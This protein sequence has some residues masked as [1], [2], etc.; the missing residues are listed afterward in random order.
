MGEIM[1]DSKHIPCWCIYVGLLVASF[2][3]S[4]AAIVFTYLTDNLGVPPALSA[5]WRL[6][7]V[8]LFQFFPC[9]H[10]WHRIHRID[11]EIQFLDYWNKEG[12]ALYEGDDSVSSQGETT[13]HPKFVLPQI[14]R[15]IPWLILSGFFFGIHFASW[16]YSLRETSMVHSL[17]WVSMGPII[18]NGGTWIAYLLGFNSS[19]SPSCFETGGAMVGLFG[20][21]IMLLDIHT[22]RKNSH[23]PS[24][25]GD[26]IALIGAMA[27]SAYLVIG[28]ELRS[29][30]PLWIY[31]FAVSLF[32]YLSC[33]AVAL[34]LG[35][36]NC[37]G[38]SSMGMFQVPYI[39][40]AMYLGVGPGIM[41]HTLLSYLVKYV[42]PLTISTVMLLE[43][44]FGSCLGYFFGMQPIP[45]WYTWVGGVVLLIGLYF[46]QFGENI[47]VN[48]HTAIP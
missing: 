31:S 23:S 24:I 39:W 1:Q 19:Q 25:H 48:Q 7:W 28:K 11:Q 9:L 6:A 30:M 32:A 17:L 20:A 26:F 43:P 34:L 18:I 27:V 47:Y 33:L 15:A 35:E 36:M 45:G 38:F 14:W 37:D 10:S 44:L 13:D 29:W 40:Y 12:L 42:S 5:S 21:M 41:G 8:T 46:I 3:C 16:T 4:S 22:E 2:T